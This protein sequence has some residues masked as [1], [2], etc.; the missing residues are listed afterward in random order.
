MGKG[1]IYSDGVTRLT[2][3]PD[4]A[5]RTATF[6]SHRQHSQPHQAPTSQMFSAS[7]SSSSTSVP[8]TFRR[9][10]AS[11]KLVTTLFQNRDHRSS[12]SPLSTRRHH[13]QVQTPPSSRLR[14]LSASGRVNITR[15]LADVRA[16]NVAVYMGSRVSV[17][18]IA[19]VLHHLLPLPLQQCPRLE[20]LCSPVSLPAVARRPPAACN[21]GGD[22]VSVSH[23]RR[24]A[25]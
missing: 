20:N 25:A 8:P 16:F 15:I 19:P 12:P 9:L 11:V 18:L 22:M 6:R 24:A 14:V 23:G 1:N 2:V 4:T 13:F 21:V 17:F 10:P 3:V 5:C 7:M